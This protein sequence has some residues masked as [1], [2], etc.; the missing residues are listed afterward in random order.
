MASQA[1]ISLAG[2][3]QAGQGTD[4]AVVDFD[5]SDAVN[6]V[7]DGFIELR[8]DA[9]TRDPVELRGRVVKLSG[10]VDSAAGSI[11]PLTI[12]TRI[13]GANGRVFLAAEIGG[14][15][16]LASL[17]TLNGQ[18]TLSIDSPSIIT[19]AG[20]S[21]A[22]ASTTLFGH[23]LTAT[24]TKGG[25]IA[26][27]GSLDVSNNQTPV[28]LSVITDGIARFSGAI[29]TANPLKGLST[30][31]LTTASVSPGSTELKGGVIRTVDDQSFGQ[32]VSL[33]ADSTLTST[34]AGT[35][36]FA[37]AVNGSQSLSV[38]TDGAITFSKG[39]GVTTPLT[40][41]TT[42]SAT[43]TTTLQG[44]SISTTGAQSYA[45]PLLLATDMTLT[46]TT[47]GAIT[48]NG[49]V[50]S[51][52][53]GKGLTIN[54]GGLTSL[55]A[56]IGTTRAL[57]S[58]STDAPGSLSLTAAN[59][60]TSGGQTYREPSITV[61]SNAAA[62][63]TLI[64]TSAGDLRLGLGVSD[65]LD[66][67]GALQ[68]ETTANAAIAG[69]AGGNSPLASLVINQAKTIDLHDV[70]TTNQQ[71]YN[72]TDTITTHSSYTATGASQPIS[73]NGPLV[74]SDDTFVVTS[75]GVV[76][77]AKSVDSD[78]VGSPRNLTINT[79]SQPQ[80]TGGDIK[81]LG[82][83]GSS[84]PLGDVNLLGSGLNLIQGLL[85]A[86]SL[87]ADTSG[88]TQLGGGSVA[89][90]NAQTYRSNVAL[91]ADT[92]LSSSAGGEIAFRRALISPATPF[93]LAVN[94]TGAT[95][96]DG[97]VGEDQLANA[98]PL[99]S[100]N[101]NVGGTVQFNGAVIRTTGAQSYGEQAIL[102]ADLRLQSDNAGAITLAGLVDGF[103]PGLS[104]LVINT[105]GLTTFGGRVGSQTALTSIT[106][107]QPGTVSLNGG[108]ITT[109]GDQLYNELLGVTLGA[110]TVL[111]AT[112][113]A[114]TIA[115]AGPVNGLVSGQQSLVINTQG[116]TRFAG[117]VGHG[118]ALQSLFT[119]GDPSPTNTVEVQG[120]SVT[121]TGFQTYGENVRIKAVND[122]DNTRFIAGGPIIFNGPVDLDGLGQPGH[123]TI[124]APTQ[125]VS[126]A[127]DVGLQ[128]PFLTVTVLTGD[129]NLNNATI[130]VNG[131]DAIN[132]NS[133]NNVPTS[134]AIALQGTRRVNSSLLGGIEGGAVFKL[135][136]QTTNNSR[137]L[138]WSYAPWTNVQPTPTESLPN[139]Y[140]VQ[141]LT[142]YNVTMQEPEY[143]NGNQFL[144]LVDRIPPPP[145]EPP[146][147]PFDYLLNALQPPANLRVPDPVALLPSLPDYFHLSSAAVG[148][149]ISFGEPSDDLLLAS[150]PSEIH[151]DVKLGFD[152]LAQA[153]GNVPST[154]RLTPQFAQPGDATTGMVLG[155]QGD[156]DY[157]PAVLE[158][159][160]VQVGAQERASV[161]AGGGESAPSLT[162][163][164][165]PLSRL[166]RFPTTPLRLEDL[167]ISGY[168]L[169]SQRFVAL[170]R[171]RKGHYSV[172]EGL[173]LKTTQRRPTG[174]EALGPDQGL[175]S[176]E[177]LLDQRQF[178]RALPEAGPAPVLDLVTIAVPTA[179][180]TVI[181]VDV[182]TDDLFRRTP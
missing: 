109:V 133:F 121:T 32:P 38:A 101:T 123:L 76:T 29:G 1:K 22:E 3:I 152:W 17:T 118:V 51:V 6:P 134:A 54:T 60:I 14:K 95:V 139:T 137:W 28:S 140:G 53:L 156:H 20:Q 171:N 153:P 116:L 49:K 103:T 34:N 93:D 111:S 129:L 110:D 62:L 41:L 84:R 166:I 128:T 36:R 97:P 13:D 141:Y 131:W 9:T 19:Q 117:P 174:L 108:S 163:Y 58:L 24:S 179:F 145:P 26:F 165:I 72:A 33:G 98:N 39:V 80:S 144:Y 11:V 94:T 96:F 81:F 87:T 138:V 18:G 91:L 122:G 25:T 102:G 40:S 55:N 48:L 113:S 149:V 44:G 126:F 162:L 157:T 57:S 130:T 132:P 45:G 115:F 21:F 180:G 59:I 167:Q 148:R 30:A 47:S 127:Q 78:S 178:S 124:E 161:Q 106:T 146:F 155:S 65:H 135:Q 170:P 100:L 86:R 136:N 90:T 69:I 73:F 168:Q 16:P 63:T 176:L 150:A 85:R 107:D 158:F 82:S 52:D 143:V 114:P 10:T 159:P 70:T 8:H 68:L 67:P 35:I 160:E 83:V 182:R 120:G 99:K 31:N 46:S 64:S 173:R 125:S 56:D 5:G 177:V 147:V 142:P 15:A 104:A 105:A 50:D 2:L 175:M 7:A 61:G 77:F 23:D 37:D 112:D 151:S 164:P 42:L 75:N 169:R 89:T 92:T 4:G 66:G 43:G 71:V 172:P 74:I 181:N 79:V 119:D 12:D 27:A 154:E 88:V